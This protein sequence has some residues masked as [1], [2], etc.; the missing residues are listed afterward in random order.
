[1]PS[2]TL[3]RIAS[4]YC[5]M[6]AVAGSAY[7]INAVSAFLAGWAVSAW[8]RSDQP[9]EHGADRRIHKIAESQHAVRHVD[10]G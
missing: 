6:A 3:A 1:M 5:G 2:V 9:A 10:L 8:T 7:L 4:I